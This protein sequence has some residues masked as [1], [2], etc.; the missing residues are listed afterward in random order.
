MEAA[1]R[2]KSYLGGPPRPFRLWLVQIAQDRL[3]NLHR[4]Q[5]ATARRAVGRE[6]PLPEQS[7]ALL[8][9]RR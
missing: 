4:R 8:A 6:Q 3:C 2:L 7:S 5:V 9:E 1:R